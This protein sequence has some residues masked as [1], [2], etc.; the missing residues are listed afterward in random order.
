MELFDL[1]HHINDAL[2]GGAMT[3]PRIVIDPLQR[4][5]GEYIH[6]GEIHITASLLN[7]TP[8]CSPTQR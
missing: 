2:F 3:P 4:Q 1:W 6:P 8:P 5:W 7:G